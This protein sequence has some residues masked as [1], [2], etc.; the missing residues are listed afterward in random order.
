[1]KVKLNTNRLRYKLVVLHVLI[2]DTWQIKIIFAVFCN[3]KSDLHTFWRENF[4]AF[5]SMVALLLWVDDG[6]SQLSDHLLI[7]QW[8]LTNPLIEQ[9]AVDTVWVTT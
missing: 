8:F 6:L 1:M 2:S 5:V 7:G 9:P 4:D 3:N